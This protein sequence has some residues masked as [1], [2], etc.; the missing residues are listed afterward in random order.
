MVSEISALAGRHKY[1]PRDK[2]VIN[3]L[4]K[5]EKKWCQRVRTRYLEEEEITKPNCNILTSLIHDT[6]NVEVV[7]HDDISYT[8]QLA[9]LS[10]Q[11]PQA[12]K[13]LDQMPSTT[14][15]ISSLVQQKTSLVE[16]ETRHSDKIVKLAERYVDKSAPDSIVKEQLQNLITSEGVD[17]LVLPHVV[18]GSVAESTGLKVLDIFLQES[19]WIVDRSLSQKG[20]CRDA[21]V[22]D[23]NINVY[24]KVDGVYRKD[25]EIMIA[26]NKN[27]KNH[28][29][30]PPPAYD[31]DQL[32]LYL[33]IWNAD[34]GI[35]HQYYEGEGDSKQ[36][37][38]KQML[39]RVREIYTS[40]GLRAS[41]KE[42]SGY[43]SEDCDHQ[44][45][46][47]FVREHLMEEF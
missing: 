1:I 41:V 15:D 21:M 45:L 37:T 6:S 19:G 40:D 44:K 30:S 5:Y 12:R 10:I 25:G 32:A 7:I 34:R 39:T 3:H 38:K 47:A 31:V 23:I 16:I 13:L 42:I 14:V 36:Y 2:A 46:M 17:K 27:R 22:G 4:L 33:F 43:M 8:E 20:K 35:L 11:Y 24:G 28:L 29:M 18:Y 26:E 9:S